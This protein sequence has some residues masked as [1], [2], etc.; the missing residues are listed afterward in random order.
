MTIGR[1]RL[2]DLACLGLAFLLFPR[3]SQSA[4]PAKPEKK[5]ARDY[6][7]V[8]SVI[9]THLDKKFAEAKIP[10]SS[11]ASDSEFLRRVYLDITGRIPSPQKAVTFL[12]SKAP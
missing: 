10:A 5:S 7:V 8:A 4:D 11:Q 1:R 3:M 2:L 12:D 9:D 6:A